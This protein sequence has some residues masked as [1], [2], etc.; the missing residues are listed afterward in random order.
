MS[1]Q[2]LN[3]FCK[4]YDRHSTPWQSLTP[5]SGEGK[6]RCDTGKNQEIWWL[7]VCLS[8]EPS[9]SNQS[10]RASLSN[11]HLVGSWLVRFTKEVATRQCRRGWL[12]PMWPQAQ[13]QLLTTRKPQEET[14]QNSIKVSKKNIY[15]AFKLNFVSHLHLF[16]THFLFLFLKQFYNTVAGTW[17]GIMFRKEH[18]LWPL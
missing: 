8:E 10:G 6:L 13:L 4:F 9:Q 16:N 2:L 7:D 15:N 18:R 14:Q 17:H 11:G 3:V 1:N 12:K 5:L